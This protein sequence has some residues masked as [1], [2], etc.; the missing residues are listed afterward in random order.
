MI[1]KTMYICMLSDTKQQE[2]INKLLEINSDFEQID[3]VLCGRI[4]DMEDIENYK[5]ILKVIE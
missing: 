1:N 2:I 3:N 4:C 5:D